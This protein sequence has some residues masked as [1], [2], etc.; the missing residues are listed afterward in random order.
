MKT[1]SK[2]FAAAVA[3]TILMSSQAFAATGS[4]HELDAWDHPVE[5]HMSAT[6][7]DFGQGT[8]RSGYG[9]PIRDVWGND[10]YSIE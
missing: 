2:L 1:T 8:L 10:I 5:G 6:E 9:E 3:S 7:S 4:L